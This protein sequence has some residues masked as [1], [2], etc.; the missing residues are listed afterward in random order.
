M[1]DAI[2][3]VMITPQDRYSGVIEC[4]KTTFKPVSD[5]LKNTMIKSENFYANKEF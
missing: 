1:K 5:L 2:I 3:T 4:I